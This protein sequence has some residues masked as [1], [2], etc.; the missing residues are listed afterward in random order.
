MQEINLARVFLETNII[1]P[2][3][4]T[5]IM[6]SLKVYLR[7]TKLTF[8][9][10]II[11]LTFSDYKEKIYIIF[12]CANISL[13][14]F[15]KCKELKTLKVFTMIDLSVLISENNHCSIGQKIKNI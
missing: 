3:L 15:F 12:M 14:K 11:K 5:N 4:E 6:L 10:I 7:P 8:L 9:E 13:F 2:P 1:V